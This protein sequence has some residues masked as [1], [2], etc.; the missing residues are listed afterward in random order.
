MRYLLTLLIALTTATA[1]ACD[2]CKTAQAKAACQHKVK[3]KANCD[4]RCFNCQEACAGCQ[5]KCRVLAQQVKQQVAQ[6]AV[7]YIPQP[8]YVP[9]E[10]GWGWGWGHHG[11]HR[12]GTAE[13][14]WRE[15]QAQQMRAFGQMQIDLAHARALNAQAYQAW[16]AAHQAH[17]D[18]FYARRMS[19]IAAQ[20]AWKIQAEERKAIN[21]I[22]NLEA[23]ARSEAEKASKMQGQK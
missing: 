23:K 10:R 11:W 20:E 14:A 19:A 18:A 4:A 21:R 3:A 13:S 1:F 12:V 15:A 8:Y 6:P 5:N 22:R 17:V 16:L 9:R 7:Q 2:K